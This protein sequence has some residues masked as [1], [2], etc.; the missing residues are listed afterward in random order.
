MAYM[1]TTGFGRLDNIAKVDGN[2]IL[3]ISLEMATT[4]FGLTSLRGNSRLPRASGED[5]FGKK[6]R[7][8]ERD[9]DAEA[10]NEDGDVGEG[11]KMALEMR[12]P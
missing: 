10:E 2:F 4:R 1:T 7:A 11:I 3:G 8:P 6:F 5:V 9:M 12:S